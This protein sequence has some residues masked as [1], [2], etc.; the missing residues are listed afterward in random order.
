MD[1]K[2][3]LNLP[4][5]QFPMK[6]NLS[7]REPQQLKEWDEL[8][9]HHQVRNSFENRQI[10]RGRNHQ[11]LFYA[12]LHQHGQGIIYHGFVINRQQLFA[13]PPGDGKQS[14][15]GTTC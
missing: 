15:S 11:N 2:K 9:L 7:K 12:C 5:S 13:D 14:G 3:T 10:L 4:K 6:A 8:N 1:Y